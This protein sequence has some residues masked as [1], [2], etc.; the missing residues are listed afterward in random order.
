MTAKQHLLN[1]LINSAAA[2]APRDR[3]MRALQV[4][5]PT[6]A[7]ALIVAP[8]AENMLVVGD[9]FVALVC[10]DNN[11]L[12]LGILYLRYITN[13]AGYSAIHT[14]TYEVE[15]AAHLMVHGESLP[16]DAYIE[17]RVHVWPKWVSLVV[18][19]FPGTALQFVCLPINEDNKRYAPIILPSHGT[20]YSPSFPCV[21]VRPVLSACPTLQGVGGW[22]R[23]ISGW[24]SVPRPLLPPPGRRP[25]LGGWVLGPGAKG[26]EIFSF[27]H[28][29]VVKVFLRGWVGRLG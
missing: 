19:S 18:L 23:A 8:Q 17:A 26:T 1:E 2:S 24:I 7:T 12:S 3:L 14:T 27:A 22:V 10:F 29:V 6:K 13:S 21:L 5:P 11:L 20:P 25:F 9:T 15:G 16:L 4:Q 28:R